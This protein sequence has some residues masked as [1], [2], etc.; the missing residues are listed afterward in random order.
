MAKLLKA[1][2]R[3]GEQFPVLRGMVT[4]SVLWPTSNLVQQSLDKTRDKYDPVE[5]LRY[6]VLGTFVTAPTVYVW[7]RLA[8]KIVRGNTVK[9]AVVKAGLEQILFAPVG[10]SQF[11]LGITILEGQ[12]WAKCVQEWREKLIPTW[13]T[14]VCIWPVLQTVNFA[15]VAEKNRVVV[16]S[17]ASFMWT[18]FLS[19]MHRLDQNSLPQFLQ[20]KSK[21]NNAQSKAPCDAVSD[22]S[23]HKYWNGNT[24]EVL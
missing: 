23:P 1:I 19:Y 15:Y 16:V 3:A 22:I 21:V 12:P 8:S 18:I 20:R 14:G 7:V 11:F 2:K 13:K 10:I 17:I 4:Y 9:H 24:N 5:S 6:L